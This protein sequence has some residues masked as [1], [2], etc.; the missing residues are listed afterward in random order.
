[1][2]DIF[3]DTMNNVLQNKFLKFISIP[4]LKFIEKK[5]FKA[6]HINLISK[7]FYQYFFEKFRTPTYSFYSHGIDGIF[8][9]DAKN[10]VRK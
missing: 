10:R 3:V 2:R 5:T 1:M 9:K 7:G 4:V 6:D 8:L